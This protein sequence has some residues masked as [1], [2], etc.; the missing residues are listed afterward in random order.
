MRRVMNRDN[1]LLVGITGGSCAGK[2]TLAWKTKQL[3]R[4][5]ESIAITC[6]RYY[7]PLDHLKPSQRCRQNF[8]SPAM[9]DLPL[10]EEHLLSLKKGK[11]VELPV[12]DYRVHTRAVRTERIESAP[13]VL[14]EGLLLLAIPSL[15]Q[16][17]DLKIYIEASD[18]TRLARR[19]RRDR[20]TRGRTEESILRQYFETVLPAYRTLIRPSRARA[21]LVVGGEDSIDSEAEKVARQ[22]R[23][24]LSGVFSG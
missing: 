14:I 9:I 12:Y 15:S 23:S 21:D 16:L 17:F 1:P 3:L 5:L 10:L 8:D 18:Q 6:D 13:V 2:S 24:L 7:K 11:M 4:P 20:E 22:I 19:L